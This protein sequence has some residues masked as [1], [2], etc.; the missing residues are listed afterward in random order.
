[1]IDYQYE[2]DSEISSVSFVSGPPSD[3]EDTPGIQSIHGK[4]L[5]DESRRLVEE[6]DAR[7]GD[8]SSGNTTVIVD[9]QKSG[10]IYI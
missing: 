6:L 7:I 3:H 5:Y 2:G 10:N 9:E 4:S 1:M 8:L